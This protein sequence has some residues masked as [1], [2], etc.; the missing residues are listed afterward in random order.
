MDVELVFNSVDSVPESQNVADTLIE[1]ASSNTSDFSALGLN[2]SS[3]KAERKNNTSSLSIFTRLK[4]D[5]MS[6]SI[7]VYKCIINAVIHTEIN[8]TTTTRMNLT[9]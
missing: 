4:A 2:T 5:L 8:G 3:I 6:I 7:N 1:A 9:L